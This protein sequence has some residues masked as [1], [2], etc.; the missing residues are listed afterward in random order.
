VLAIK[1]TLYPHLGDSPIV[2]ALID[3]AEAGKQVVRLSRIKARFDEQANIKWA[4]HWKGWRARRLRADR[5]QDALQDVFGGAPR[6]FDDP[7]LL[8][9]R[10]RQLQNPK[11]ARLYEDVAC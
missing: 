2:N 4:A 10:H 9:Y 6:G 8:P 3:A 11:T 1:Q 7:A 5:A